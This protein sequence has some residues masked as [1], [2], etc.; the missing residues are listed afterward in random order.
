MVCRP[1][2]SE[3]Q[4]GAAAGPS[5]PLYPVIADPHVPAAQA[6]ASGGPLHHSTYY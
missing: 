2:D 6:G 4:G 3:Q 5:V 1:Q